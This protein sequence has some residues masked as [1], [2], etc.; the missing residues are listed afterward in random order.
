MV[1]GP[2][3]ALLALDEFN[4][5]LLALNHHSS[6]PA[7]ALFPALNLGGTRDSPLP[8]LPFL[9]SHDLE[10]GCG[11]GL[12]RTANYPFQAIGH[13]AEVSSAMIRTVVLGWT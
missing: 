7:P 1:T 4:A 10:V 8:G 11:D 2:G 9:G 6:C 12:E 3:G 13:H 5:G